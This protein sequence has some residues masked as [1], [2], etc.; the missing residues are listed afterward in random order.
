MLETLQIN[1]SELPPFAQ[2]GSSEDKA[3]Q[4]HRLLLD[5]SRDESEKEL[6]SAA[7]ATADFFREKFFGLTEK[8]IRS[9]ILEVLKDYYDGEVHHP[10]EIDNLSEQTGIK[11]E[12][13]LPVLKS[14]V[15]DGTLLEGRR[16]RWQEMGEHYNPLYKLKG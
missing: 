7:R 3:R 14:M 16:R 1:A 6:R 12:K 5:L 9:R 2:I 10:L 11:E 13:L 8:Q 15:A 4:L